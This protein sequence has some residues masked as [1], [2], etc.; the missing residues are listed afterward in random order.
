MEKFIESDPRQGLLLP[1]DLREWVPEDDLSHFVLAALERVPMD[2]FRFN[3]R[4]SGSAQYHPRMMLALLVY[5]YANGVSGSRR[6]ER[7]PYRDLGTRYICADTHPDHDTICKFRRENFEAI[8]EVF[9][10]VL[11]LAQEL[12]LLQVGIVSVDGTKLNANASKHRSVRYDRAGELSKKLRADVAS[13]L[14]QAEQ[15]DR[16]NA[17]D[18]QA[19][20]KELARREAL[21]A[22]LD[23]ARERL[24]RKAKASAERDRAEYE[25]KL[26]EREKRPGK[27]KGPPPQPPSESPEPSEQS[28]L[29]DPDSALMRR[30]RHHEYR[31]AYNAQAVVDAQGSQLILGARVSTC[32]NDARELVADIESVPA[33]LG[34]PGLVLADNGY[35]SE[36]EVH[37]L[38]RQDIIPLV[39]TGAEGRQRPYDFRPPKPEKAPPKN[40]AAWLTQMQELLDT[41]VGQRLYRL[42]QQTV[43]PVFGIIKHVLGF[44]QFHLRGAEKVNGEWQL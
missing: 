29:T 41:E 44:R 33:A 19:L 43:E 37:Q 14:E 3:T 2:K 28:N 15:A 17:V 39:S 27:R 13:L 12:K 7:A 9:L 32:A 21:A 30:S 8:A 11:L 18:P 5:S 20:P 26:A 42:R 10:Q 22:K 25:R 1:V 31:Q 23:E 36:R 4:G 24:E 34:R 40:R 6:T 38:Q 35:A 16:S